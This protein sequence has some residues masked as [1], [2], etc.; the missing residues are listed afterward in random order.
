DCSYIERTF[1]Q[2]I[3]KVVTEAC[4]ADQYPFGEP[5]VCSFISRAANDL[6]SGPVGIRIQQAITD[7]VRN[8]DAAA[9]RAQRYSQ[10]RYGIQ[11]V[12]GIRGQCQ[13]SIC[14]VGKCAFRLQMLGSNR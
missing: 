14:I 8:A 10:L 11:A 5:I 6:L 12:T 9:D 3:L 7:S 1:R 13:V 4:E 2:V